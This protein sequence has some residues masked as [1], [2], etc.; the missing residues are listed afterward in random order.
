MSPRIGVGGPVSF[1]ADDVAVHCARCLRLIFFRPHA[2]HVDERICLDCYRGIADGTH[3][4][5]VTPETLRE[6][7]LY[8][9]AKGRPQ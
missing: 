6:V 4:I 3:R 2:P 9:L 8:H 7:L 1:F 5:E